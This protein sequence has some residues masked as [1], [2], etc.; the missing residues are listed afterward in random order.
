[1]SSAP[2]ATPSPPTGNPPR[3]PPFWRADSLLARSFLLIALL[4]LLSLGGWF[5]IYRSYQREP[6]AREIAQQ[7]TTTINLT[8][9]AIV[10]SDP[11]LRRELLLDLNETE[12]I[13][14]YAGS[15]EEK[16]EPVPEEV[17]FELIGGRI[18]ACWTSTRPRASASTRAR[19]RRSS[20]RCRKR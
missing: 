9:A 18:K 13:R 17:M 15:P 3:S 4:L 20:S 19:R 5:Q 10:N 2:P 12:G 11:R 8:R 1:V 14:V 7:M 6:I 16:L